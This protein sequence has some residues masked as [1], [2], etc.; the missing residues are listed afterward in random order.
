M[1]AR[2]WLVLGLIGTILGLTL[3]GCVQLKAPER[4]TVGGSEPID[5]RQV[6]HPRTLDEAQQELNRAY[7]N[8]R[9]LE[10]ENRDLREKA[11]EYKRERDECRKERDRYK[12]RLE[13][14]KD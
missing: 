9:H 4:I 8:V 6:P 3:P 13:K 11:A 2:A 10:Q 5:T 12:D 1:H 14:R 7:A